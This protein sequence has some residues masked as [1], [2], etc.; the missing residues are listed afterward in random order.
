M[1]E[2]L[3]KPYENSIIHHKILINH[4]GNAAIPKF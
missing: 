4:Y 3:L 1:S 2:T